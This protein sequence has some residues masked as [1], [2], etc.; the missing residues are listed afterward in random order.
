MLYRL[1]DAPEASVE[2]DRDFES[3]SNAAGSGTTH[4][5]RGGLIAPGSGVPGAGAGAKSSGGKSASLRLVLEV[6]VASV[7]LRFGVHALQRRLTLLLPVHA[8]AAAA[9]VRS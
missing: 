4:P 7:G 6:K 2:S 3:A 5:C 1:Q 9:Y 8:H